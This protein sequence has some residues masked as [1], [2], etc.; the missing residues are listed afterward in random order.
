MEEKEKTPEGFVHRHPIATLLGAAAVAL[1]GGIELAAGV[2]IGGGVAALAVRPNGVRTVRERAR[3]L[4][5]RAPSQVKERARAVMQA[6]R[7]KRAATQT[8]DGHTAHES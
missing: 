3:A 1:L 5:D 4:L 7:G 8:T 6:A 2:L